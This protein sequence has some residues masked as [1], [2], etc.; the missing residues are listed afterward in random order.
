MADT[1]SVAFGAD[2]AEPRQVAAVSPLVAEPSP[3]LRVLLGLNAPALV[4]LAGVLAVV[5]A[6]I[7]S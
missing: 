3:F 2:R 1:A 6:E 4:A 5:S 7:V